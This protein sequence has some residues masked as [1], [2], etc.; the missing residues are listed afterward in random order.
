M[1]KKKFHKVSRSKLAIG[2]YY[3]Q[4]AVVSPILIP[5]AII[6]AIAGYIINFWGKYKDWYLAK[7]LHR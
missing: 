3:V 6:G 1:K 5:L 4:M 7:T 2:F